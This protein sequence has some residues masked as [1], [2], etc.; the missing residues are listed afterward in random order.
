MGQIAFP[1]QGTA[2]DFLKITE[3]DNCLKFYW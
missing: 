2:A 3:G 1:K